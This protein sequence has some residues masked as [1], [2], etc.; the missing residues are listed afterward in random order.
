MA[1]WLYGAP[2]VA[3][4]SGG[5]SGIGLHIVRALIDEGTSIAIFDLSIEQ[6]LLAELR[7]GCSR[8]G[9]VVEAYSVDVSNSAAML[10]A[11]DEAAIYVGRPDLAFNSAGILRTALFTEL[12]AEVFETVVRINLLGSRNFSAA[13]LKHMQANGHLVLVASLA[14]VVGSYTQ[15]AYAAS[16]FGVVGLAEVLRI[17]QKLLGIDVSVVCPGEISTPLLAYERQHGSPIT[18]VLNQFAGVLPVE[19]AV[20]GILNGVRRREF[21]ITPG[22]KARLTRALARKTSTL[23]RWLVDRTLEKAITK[24]R[25]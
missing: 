24:A 5:A 19:K 22:F 16:K 6:S 11:M 4:I 8:L 10:S 12:A 7:L 13:A 1:S 20:A 3:F 21:M 23:M 15:S 2:Q 25:G 18:E 9:Q 17:E 14:G